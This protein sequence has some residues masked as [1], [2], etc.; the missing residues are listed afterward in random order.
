MRRK[1]EK[2]LE[3]ANKKIDQLTGEHIHWD[4]IW[5]K[6]KY[7]YGTIAGGDGK[8]KLRPEEEWVPDFIETQM[9]GMDKETWIA[10]KK[11]QTDKRL[12]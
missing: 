6:L 5:E 12:R 2:E 10:M 1:Y 9:N 4:D 11:E 3:E 7:M 8:G